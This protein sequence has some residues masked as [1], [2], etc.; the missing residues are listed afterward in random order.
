MLL[1]E[2][3]IRPLAAAGHRATLLGSDAISLSDKRPYMFVNQGIQCT[4][5][6][7]AHRRLVICLCYVRS[8]FVDPP[9]HR[10]RHRGGVVG[11]LAFESRDVLIE[12]C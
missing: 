6:V 2:R 4:L 5:N 9:A 11:A 7:R 1:F 3:L 10:P 8:L 12:A